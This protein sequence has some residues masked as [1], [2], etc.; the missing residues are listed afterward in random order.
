MEEIFENNALIGF[1]T[2]TF[3]NRYIR[4]TF[5]NR[6]I[7]HTGGE[8]GFLNISK[9]NISQLEGAIGTVMTLLLD[10]RG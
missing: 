4:H 2:I 5:E 6:S 10:S 1:D 9:L 7:R 3:E 8:A